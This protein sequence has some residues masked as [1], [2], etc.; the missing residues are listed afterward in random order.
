MLDRLLLLSGNDIPF[1][2]ARLTIHPPTIKEIAYIT[3]TRFWHGCEILNFNKEILSDQDKKGLSN[4]SNFNII[5]STIQ[6]K[7]LEGIQA[8]INVLSILAILFPLYEISL[9]KDKDAIYLVHNETKEI[10]EINND[11][12]QVFKEILSNMFCL[13]QNEKEYNP[14]GELAKRIADKFKKGAQ[15][16]AKMSSE[17][18]SVIEI[19][20]RYVSILAVGENKNIN[21][22]MNYTVY[23]LMDQFNRFILKM[24]YDSW[25][26]YRIAGATGLETPEEWLKDLYEKKN[27][28]FIKL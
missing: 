4:Y 11:N 8:R 21:Q 26:Q 16:R 12:F 9:A 23:Q 10:C 24:Q 7:Q 5:M 28:N 17:K 1:S 15:Q 27:N 2:I 19:L 25:T 14:R 18:T 22:L 13:S 3:E 20:S 6:E